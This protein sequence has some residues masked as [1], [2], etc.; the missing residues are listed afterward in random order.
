MLFLK[1][2]ISNYLRVVQEYNALATS[3]GRIITS[4]H[5]FKQLKVGGDHEK[6]PIDIQV[7]F[8]GHIWCGKSIW[9]RDA[10]SFEMPPYTIQTG[11]DM[12]LSAV[13]YTHYGV[14]T[15][16]PKSCPNQEIKDWGYGFMDKYASWKQQNPQTRSV[17]AIYWIQKRNWLTLQ[18]GIDRQQKILIYSQNNT[19]CN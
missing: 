16:V 2:S 11:E 12:M 5:P 4:L 3:N 7:D 19:L 6:K 1:K 10:F 18:Q 9:L 8:G 15:I 14:P 17:M 13:L